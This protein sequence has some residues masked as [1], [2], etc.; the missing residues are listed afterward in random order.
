M[1]SM[2]TGVWSS[3][4]IAQALSVFQ[5]VE[6][7]PPFPLSVIGC[8]YV[9]DGPSPTVLAEECTLHEAELAKMGPEM[10]QQKVVVM[11]TKL[12]QLEEELYTPPTTG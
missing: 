12:K 6:Y 11:E 4:S 3:I 10:F 7:V 8:Y 1:C 9:I 5:E 2:R